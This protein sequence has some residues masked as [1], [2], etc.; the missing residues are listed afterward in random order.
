MKVSECEIDGCDKKQHGRG[1]C[2]GHYRRWRKGLTGEALEKPLR[3]KVPNGTSLEKRLYSNIKK[4]GECWEWQGSTNQGYGR[5][6]YEGKWHLTHRLSWK[7]AKGDIPEGKFVCHHCD[8]PKCI[9]PAH[10]FLGTHD[11][12]MRDMAEKGRGRKGGIPDEQVR[13]I[14]KDPRT[15]QVISD[16]YGITQQTISDIKTGKSYAWVEDE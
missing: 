16:E 9:R 6:G 1:M 5:I 15:Q 10:L 14:R 11:D 8:N 2:R 3:K 7:V 13:A 12:N 4:V